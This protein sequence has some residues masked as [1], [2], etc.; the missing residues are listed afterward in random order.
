MVVEV[1]VSGPFAV[2]VFVWPLREPHE[3]V[4]GVVVSPLL[5]S[6]SA[7]VKLTPRFNVSFCVVTENT[8]FVPPGTVTGVLV[9]VIDSGPTLLPPPHPQIEIRIA[10]AK[11]KAENR[12]INPP[13]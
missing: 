4:Q 6:L 7:R 11:N 12:R 1:K 5:G 2:T 10:P 9:K 8:K 13:E 3:V